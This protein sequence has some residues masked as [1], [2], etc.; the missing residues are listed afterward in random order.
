MPKVHS[1]CFFFNSI[2][3]KSFTIKYIVRTHTWSQE[4]TGNTGGTLI[5]AIDA[6]DSVGAKVRDPLAFGALKPLW[7][8][9]QPY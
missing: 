4:G 7:M 3:S 6:K 9:G 2:L 8:Y 1:Y 5:A